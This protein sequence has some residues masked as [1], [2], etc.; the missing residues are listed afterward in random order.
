[1]TYLK[2]I[3]ITL[4]TFLSFE[5]SLQARS[6]NK[7]AKII[8]NQGNISITE[9][10]KSKNSGTNNSQFSAEGALLSTRGAK[11][12]LQVITS[13]GYRL[14]LGSNTE[15]S[16]NYIDNKAQYT[17]HTGHMGIDAGR[18]SCTVQTTLSSVDILKSFC[19]IELSKD[20]YGKEAQ[21]TSCIDCSNGNVNI[22]THDNEQITSLQAGETA[23]CTQSE[24]ITVSKTSVKKLSQIIENLGISFTNNVN[25][26]LIVSPEA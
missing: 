22:H 1:M 25:D 7:L 19:D 16:I 15:V 8:S 5:L 10:N 17:L 12:G 13:E 21:A 9:A 4:I 26:T 14:Y 11:S 18:G 2:F 3:I 24:H 20:E 6:T 23:T